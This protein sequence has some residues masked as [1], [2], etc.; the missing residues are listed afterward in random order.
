MRN[1]VIRRI[2]KMDESFKEGYR[3]G[4]ED[5]V[6][7]CLASINETGKLEDARERIEEYLSLIKEDKIER[8]KKSLWFISKDS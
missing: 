4:F 1:V 5:A 2:A 3:R 8:L 6:E 7:F